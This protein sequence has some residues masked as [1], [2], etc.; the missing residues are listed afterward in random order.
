MGN[1]MVKE[2]TLTIVETSMWEV[3]RMG[4]EMVKEQRLSM[5]EESMLG[6]TRMG[7]SGTEYFMK[8]TETYLES[9]LTE[10]I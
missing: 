4:N 2:H 3:G 7:N 1:E 5:M 9:G 8:I 10:H 6:I